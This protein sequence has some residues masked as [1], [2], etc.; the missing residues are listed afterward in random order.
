MTNVMSREDRATG[1]IG[2]T[3]R[4]E[5]T[6]LPPVAGYEQGSL[7]SDDLGQLWVASPGPLWIKANIVT[8]D[9]YRRL[10]RRSR[11][12]LAGLALLLPT[13]VTAVILST[14]WHAVAW[15]GVL[16]VPA[17]VLVLINLPRTN[18]QL[19]G[20]IVQPDFDAEFL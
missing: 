20:C 1:R 6:Q 16:I 8:A 17:F 9:E 15:S 10:R 14:I 7:F 18:K 11:W 5:R 4:H 13:L 19:L 12:L 3:Y 2:R